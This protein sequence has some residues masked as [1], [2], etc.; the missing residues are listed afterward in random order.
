MLILRKILRPFLEWQ[1]K[2]LYEKVNYR[3]SNLNL[4]RLRE[5][6]IERNLSLVASLKEITALKSW[7]Q[8]SNR[9]NFE[10]LI[11]KA[12][13]I[14]FPQKI[15]ISLEKLKK[16]QLENFISGVIDNKTFSND[17]KEFLLLHTDIHN[18]LKTKAQN[19]LTEKY[20]LF[21]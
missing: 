2:K 21:S 11:L 1:Q 7:S 13:L 6:V 14:Y 16:D 20:P 9:S 4:A 12:S 10:D 17:E 8:G 15:G 18:K 5:T 3:I 19:L